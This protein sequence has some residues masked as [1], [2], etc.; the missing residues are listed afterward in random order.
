MSKRLILFLLCSITINVVNASGLDD[1]S[2][3][4]ASDLGPLLSLLGEATT[5][6][7]LSESTESIDYFIF[8]MAP[9]GIIS[10][11]TAVIRLYGNSSLR[12]FIG[13]AK[14]R[15]ITAEAELC[16]S[17]SEDV[18]ELF[19]KGGIT[20]VFGRSDI[21]ELVYIPTELNAEPRFH[22]FTQYLKNDA[23]N[24]RWSE[25][26][27]RKRHAGSDSAKSDSKY[28]E[29][30]PKPNISLNL[31]LK[32]QS[33][34][35]LYIVAAIGLMLQSGI[36]IFAGIGPWILGWNAQKLSSEAAQDYAP[37]I[38]IA[39]TVALCLGIWS[40]A[41]LVGQTS[42]GRT[43][44]RRDDSSRIYWVQLGRQVIG[45]QTFHAFIHSDEREPLTTW[46]SWTKLPQ[47]KDFA[48]YIAISLVILG[49]IAQFIG[50][51]GL[52]AWVSIAQL[53]I[54]L[55]MSIL[56][57]ALRMHRLDMGVN[58]LQ[59]SFGNDND[60]AELDEWV[61]GH[62]LDWLAVEVSGKRASKKETSIQETPK[63]GSSKKQIHMGGASEETHQKNFIWHITGQH[64]NA[65][66]GTDEADKNLLFRN[67]IR[68]SH[69]TGHCSINKIKADD[70]QLWEDDRVKVR[71]KAKDLSAAIS[72]AAATLLPDSTIKETIDL[73]VKVMVKNDPFPI[74]A[75]E[76]VDLSQTEEAALAQFLETIS[77]KM[78]PPNGLDHVNWTTDSSQLEAVLGLWYWSMT[79][80]KDKHDESVSSLIVKRKK[81]VF[82]IISACYGSQK[83]GNSIEAYMSLW[84]GSSHLKYE[85][86]SLKIN[87]K[88][89]YSL[90][91][92]WLPVGDQNGTV[93]KIRR[94]DENSISNYFQKSHRICG[95]NVV[96]DL[97]QRDDTFKEDDIKIQGFW[98]KA[99]EDPLLD[100]CVQE[101]YTTLLH[102]MKYLGFREIENRNMSTR[103]AGWNL[104]I[105]DSAITALAD[106]FKDNELGTYADAISCLVPLLRS[107][108]R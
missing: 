67:R 105:E 35:V 76:E 26:S 2:N 80:K 98:I 101:L 30:A 28:V 15:Q 12:A 48:I 73:K 44:K 69:L 54:T 87:K 18:C 107:E 31:G 99:N 40:C 58:L 63:E 34:V 88:N 4:L 81:R 8:A 25:I 1:F 102:S 92:F 103:E 53:A 27:K 84:Q 49:Y 11:I 10:T 23:G 7:Y 33:T 3:N 43:F 24:T 42:D 9:I 17:T 83:L 78:M 14:E 61:A 38:F 29:F 39:G 62:E 13:K 5:I 64:E 90:A 20:R 55:V 41:V 100:M 79:S 75:P 108:F 46:T 51:R 82:K 97:L 60:S 21:I 57:G 104:Q 71:L 94:I 96:Y 89:K 56:R 32:R 65:T 66:T 6:Q 37:G 68:L 70:Y 45:D 95:W 86:F 16:T 50:L 52:N 91:D 36:I 47:K 77:I 93:K 72:H 74:P 22:L 19:D 85:R 106:F 59:S